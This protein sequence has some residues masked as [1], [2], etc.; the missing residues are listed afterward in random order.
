MSMVVLLSV[1][2]LIGSSMI[3]FFRLKEDEHRQ[4]GPIDASASMVD[5]TLGR[6]PLAGAL[7]VRS[8]LANVDSNTPSWLGYD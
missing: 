8:S 2:F 7:V 1:S 5:A 6:S 4:Q 3:L